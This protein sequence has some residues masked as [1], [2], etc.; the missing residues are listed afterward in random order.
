MNIR[1]G[2][3]PGHR[4]LPGQEMRWA[5]FAAGNT[6]LVV[7]DPGGLG[8]G[9]EPHLPSRL[10]RGPGRQPRLAPPAQGRHLRLIH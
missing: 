3:G 5:E 1:G 6:T 7:N 4:L 10:H 2:H 9:I 8:V